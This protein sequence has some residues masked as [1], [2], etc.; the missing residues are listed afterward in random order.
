MN[1]AQFDFIYNEL[2]H[3]LNDLNS[4]ERLKNKKIFITG[5][6]GFIGKW[7][8]LS[9]AYLNSKYALNISVIA[10]SRKMMNSS[11]VNR[12]KKQNVLFYDLDVCDPFEIPTDVN[13]I[14]HLAGNPDRRVHAS[15]PLRVIKTNVD[16]TRN[17]LDAASRV[18]NIERILV[19]SSGLINGHTFDIERANTIDTLNFSSSYIDSKRLQENICH[20]Y[21]R[22]FQLPIGII[23]P[24]TFVGPLQRL[25]RPW[26]I[27]NFINSAIHGRDL[28]ILGDPETEKSFLYPTEML[29]QIYGYLIRGDIEKPWELGSSDKISLKNIADI[30]SKQTSNHVFI[31]DEKNRKEKERIN[32]F[33]SD[34]RYKHVCYQN[35]ILK[36]LAWYRI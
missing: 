27:N 19:F 3:A 23:R 25:D 26:A 17:V 31:E 1:D 29:E 20:I 24:Y 2:S 33:V 14:I 5:A 16:G 7:L 35:I 34:K 21:S 6:S 28:T 9:L 15:D 22:K 32:L 36:T 13:V 4:I 11:L 30:I 10:T 8:L 18:E 12:I